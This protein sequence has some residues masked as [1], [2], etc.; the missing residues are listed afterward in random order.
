M[1]RPLPRLGQPGRERRVAGV[2]Q[3]VTPTDGAVAVDLVGDPDRGGDDRAGVG[4]QVAGEA[5]ARGVH[6]EAQQVAVAGEAGAE[7]AAQAGQRQPVAQQQ[8]RRAEGARGQHQPPCAD[9]AHGQ[10][11]RGLAVGAGVHDVGDL[12]AAALVTVERPEALDLVT[13]ADVGAGVLGRRQV[14]VV[15]GVLGAVVAAHVALAGEGAGDPRQAVDVAVRRGLDLALPHRL[16]PRPAREADGQRRALQRQAGRLGGL[17]D[18]HRLGSVV[19]GVPRDADHRLDRVVVGLEVGAGDRASARSRR[20]AP[21]ARGR[22]T[23]RPCAG[24]RWRRS[25]SHRPGRWR[26]G[27][28]CPRSSRRRRGRGGPRR[29][30]RSSARWHSAYARSCRAGRRGLARGRRPSGRRRPGGR[31]P[32]SRRNPNQRRQRRPS[33]SRCSRPWCGVPVDDVDVFLPGLDTGWPRG[34]LGSTTEPGRYRSA[35]CR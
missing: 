34:W 8:V 14:G 33:R 18:R 32:P 12:V 11:D 16:L 24:A 1:P 21:A 29:A 26:P 9:G 6:D 17:L 30:P 20:P 31:P 7:G 13:G 23:S 25:A 15:E 19:V 2:L 3:V 28:R 22:T 5:V 35:G 10:V 4:A 27:R